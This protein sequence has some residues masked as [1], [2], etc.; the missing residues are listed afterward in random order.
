MRL[1]TEFRRIKEINYAL[2]FRKMMVP[3]RSVFTLLFTVVA[4]LGNATTY[5]VSNT[6]DDNASG[7]SETQAWRTIDRVNQ[8][9]YSMQPGDNVLFERGGKFRGQ[10]LIGL[11]GTPAAPITVGA[12]G[13]GPLPVLS[14]SEVITGWT[15]HS[16]NVW[17]AVV[18]NPVDQ[19]FA[20]GELQEI[21]RYPNSGWLR[22]DIGS[23]T[24]INDADL[25]QPD[26]YWDGATAIV[27][28]SNWGY[29]EVTVTG[30]TT[31]QLNLTNM[32][33][34]V[35]DYEW[36]Y[37]L[38]NKLSELDM[39]GE[40]FY[41]DNTQLLY[42]WPPNNQDPNTMIIESPIEDRGVWCAQDYAIVENIRF[43]HH[44]DKSVFLDAVEHCIVRNCEFGKTYRAVFSYGDYNTIEYN[45][46][47][48]V[49]ATAVHII[50]HNS[51]IRYNNFNN[52]A[53]TVGEG[54]KNGWGYF[55]VRVA[56][57]DNHVHNNVLHTI[58]YIGIALDGNTLVEKNYV[59]NALALLNDGAG[60]AF[61][62]VDDLI[63]QD[64]VVVNIEGTLE[65]SAPDFVSYELISVGI[66]FGNTDI[67]NTI[68]RRNT[69][70]N[71]SGGAIHVD[72][73][74]SSLNN[75]IRD[76]LLYNN[77]YQLSISDASNYTGPAATP[78]YFMP[79]YN[80]IYDGNILFCTKEEQLCSKIL[81]VHTA[82]WSDWGTFANNYYFNPFNE[83][84]ILVTDHFAGKH[85][86]Y[87]LERWQADMGEGATS[88]ETAI[89]YN[90]YEVTNVNSANMINNS[91]FDSDVI[92]WEGWPYE[93]QL[94]QDY[95]FLDNGAL[96]VVF[97][98]N[99]SYNTFTH[100]N[101]PDFNVTSGNWYRARFSLQS[102][103]IGEIRYG[104]KGASQVTGP[105]TIYQKYIPFGPDRRDIEIIF[106]SDLTDAARFQFTN[107]YLESTYWLDNVEVHEVQ[108]APVDPA[109][110]FQLLYNVQSTAQTYNLI[111]CWSDVYGAYYSGSVTLQPWESI[112]LIKQPDID[113]GLT[114][115]ID[116]EEVNAEGQ[117]LLYPNPIQGGEMLQFDPVK[118]LTTVI[119]MD[120]N[121]KVM[122]QLT[123]QEGERTF[124][125][126]GNLASGTYIVRFQEEVS[127]RVQRI[128][129]F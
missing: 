48:G 124:A 16:G 55:G 59:D 90:E 14:G 73:T 12:Y 84:S 118:D 88:L 80:D 11:P 75:E 45:D 89:R 7:T 116:D 122:Q 21:A 94:T 98:D 102:N 128:T 47:D 49:Y 77:K 35:Q 37:Y 69:V 81:Q 17:T 110:R 51:V 61:D 1:K 113:C 43:E 56:G 33:G 126:D 123:L 25:T 42:F 79:A 99:T 106:Q 3:S 105:N 83:Q 20:N 18:T 58:G 41:D 117:L 67:Q 78:P 50:D 24:Q 53:M 120:L 8:I 28:S 74:M 95:T 15:P 68:V 109:D 115:G 62:H 87:N 96:K 114:T 121:G 29:D 111:G 108:V 127:D 125:L 103:A 104:L 72:H 97:D 129:V 82:G 27:R 119:V 23:F 10:L 85:Y 71:C 101:T 44:I 112:A 31:G 46:F 64:N 22:N 91:T 57:G 36:G 32:S 4:L 26:G 5:Y 40:W 60:I 76:N 93:A 13:T 86:R 9:T 70:A 65:S 54:E 107:H 34:T 63:I 38:R 100:Y 30:Y 6:G 19:I 2:A 66:Y 92:G 39:A 52:I